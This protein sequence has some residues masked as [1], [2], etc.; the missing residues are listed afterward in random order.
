[1]RTQKW[2]GPKMA[3]AQIRRPPSKQI[4]NFSQP[5]LIHQRAHPKLR[6]S[7]RLVSQVRPEDLAAWARCARFRRSALPRH[8]ARLSFQGLGRFVAAGA[9]DAGDAGESGEAEA[10]EV[11]QAAV[12]SQRSLGLGLL[13][14]CEINPSLCIRGVLLSKSDKSH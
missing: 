8:L 9:G 7:P 5:F 14:P 4:I 10:R 6:H 3:S 2:L 13:T 12:G 11:L 1:M